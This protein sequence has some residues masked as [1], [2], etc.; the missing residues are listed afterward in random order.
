MTYTY[1]KA[2]IKMKT[3]KI[4]QFNENN[5]SIS[6]TKIIALLLAKNQCV[7]CILFLK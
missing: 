4:K 6:D 3:E 2:K 1:N 7:L 5:N